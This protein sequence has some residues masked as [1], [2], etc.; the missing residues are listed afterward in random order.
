MAIPTDLTPEEKEIIKDGGIPPRHQAE[1]EALLAKMPKSARAML[2][3]AYKA[4]FAEAQ[5]KL[6]LEER[7][8]GVDD[9]NAR[10]DEIVGGLDDEFE[11]LQGASDEAGA[12][13]T[14]ALEDY[15]DSLGGYDPLEATGYAGDVESEAAF[16]EADGRSIDAQNR[17]LNKYGGLMDPE[18]T[19]K[20]QFL[21]EQARVQEE[22]DR[23][24]AMDAALR[25][26]EMRGARSGG[27]EIAAL[28]GAQQ[29]T[30][31]NRLMQDLGTQA[32]AVDRAMTAMEGYGRTA[33]SMRTASF[34]EDFKRGT[35]A[36]E[37]SMWNKEALGDYNMWRDEFTQ[38]ER[39]R[40]V[41]RDGSAYDARNNTTNR[42]F[43]RAG[44][45]YNEKEDAAGLKLGVEGDKE[46]SDTDYLKL[47]L[48]KIEADD[49]DRELEDEEDD[50]F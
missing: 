47:G 22:M 31:Q 9:T 26:L 32:G 50:L 5:T 37:I 28:T 21:M 11:G 27:A 38:T 17:L 49:A 25:D 34:D 24:S 10:R 13:D 6:L 35:A 44:S 42:I 12:S 14:Q 3:E 15:L 16:A 18:V 46:S 20:E 8:E 41:E 1:F 30:S 48:G 29:I 33:D 36:D 23:R 40:S 2:R 45:L 7:G 4:K 43:G 39:D 19:A